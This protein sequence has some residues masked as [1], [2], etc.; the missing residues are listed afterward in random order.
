MFNV[1]YVFTVR[2]PLIWRDVQFVDVFNIE[3]CQIVEIFNLRC[4][5]IVDVFPSRN[6][7]YRIRRHMRQMYGV[8]IVHIA[9]PIRCHKS[10][11]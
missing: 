2:M 11:P 8:V 3:I 9:K 4:V 6:A 7:L 10:D 5:Q 1:Y